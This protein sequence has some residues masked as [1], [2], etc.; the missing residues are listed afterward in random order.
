M[1][2][3]MSTSPSALSWYAASKFRHAL[4]DA[5]L[6]I[7]PADHHAQASY[8]GVLLYF[9]A[10]L[11]PNPDGPW[12]PTYS[13][14]HAW[15]TA[16]LMEVVI[17]AVFVAEKRAIGVEN[18]LLE[19]LS[20]LGLARIVA[21]GVMIAFIVVRELKLRSSVPKSTPEERQSLLENGQG[22]TPEYGAAPAHAHGAHPPIA[23]VSAKPPAV[24][25]T[26]WLDYFAGFRVL[27]PYLWYEQPSSSSLSTRSS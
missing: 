19:T 22:S 12:S 13:H 1:K 23:P 27:F 5:L 16:V 17:T 25:N 10:G 18:D 26:G 20:G 21:L 15:I 7:S 14:C 2:M 8:V 3:P 4:S 11:L 6:A 9:L 24:Q